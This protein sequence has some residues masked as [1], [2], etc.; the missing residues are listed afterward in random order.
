LFLI[1]STNDFQSIAA[2]SRNSYTIYRLITNNTGLPA[3]IT[4]G[5][6]YWNAT[7]TRPADSVMTFQV[8]GVSVGRFEKYYE[9]AIYAKWFGCIPDDGIDDS[10][11][12]QKAFNFAIKYGKSAKVKF[13]GGVFNV[14]NIVIADYDGSG[15]ARYVSLEVSGAA[16]VYDANSISS[17]VTGFNVSDGLGFGIA[18]QHGANVTIRN[19]AFTG[20]GFTPSGVDG[21]I[22]ATASDW[23]MGGAISDTIDHPNAGIVIDPF[24]SDLTGTHQYPNSRAWYSNTIRT[25]SSMVNI[26]DC[27][28]SRFLV[29]VMVAPNSYTT[30][31]DNI[32]VDNAY[33]QNLKVFWGAG[34]RQS[35]DNQADHIYSIGPIE[36]VFNG[37]RFGQQTGTAPTFNH[38]SFA[39]VTKYLYYGDV[40]FAGIKFND[41]Y[42]EG[43]WSLGVSG[44]SNPVEFN[45]CEINLL[46]SGAFSAPLLHSGG[47]IIFTGGVIGYFDNTYAN[48]LPFNCTSVVINGTTMNSGAPVNFNNAVPYEQISIDNAIYNNTEALSFLKKGVVDNYMRY[49]EKVVLPETICKNNL[50]IEYQMHDPYIEQVYIE[51]K[52]LHLNTTDKTA[53]FLSSDSNSYSIGQWVTTNT[54]IDYS[55]DFFPAS[56]TGLGYVYAK[57]NDTIR[58][59][60]VPFGA[61]STTSYDLSTT[62]MKRIIQ[63]VLYSSTINN[64]TLTIIHPAVGGY[65][66]INNFIKGPGIGLNA[67]ILWTDGTKIKM[68]RKAT[69]SVVNQ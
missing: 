69:A 9:D 38:C 58:L 22:T 46:T 28:F 13:E 48:G 52:T 60:Y 41:V 15:N 21:A 19:I 39:G 1:N 67:R 8:T 56:R 20:V 36:T 11:Q 33:L 18:V 49:I 2:G 45:G 40:N 30:N 5:D 29:G 62:R 14:A 53:Y 7:S 55:N 47:P 61:D 4:I 68:S 6:Y 37:K 31:A 10:Y 44:G 43:L 42:T 27:S 3:G 57:R 65:P 16:P 32:R 23:N 26:L 25:G 34:Q 17:R 66:G 63:R 35:R 54:G 59:A 50:G 12:A 64:D 51:N 24:T